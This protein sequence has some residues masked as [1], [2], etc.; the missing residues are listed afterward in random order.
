M[1]PIDAGFSKLERLSA[2]MDGEADDAAFEAA[3]ASWRN[4]ELDRSSW[5]AW[6]LI[7]DVLRSEELGGTAHREAAFVLSLRSRLNDEPSILAPVAR[8]AA[9]DASDVG[10]AQIAGASASRFGRVR[11][12]S[13]RAWTASAAVA[14]GFVV[15]AGALVVMQRPVATP[16]QVQAQAAPS[17]DVRLVSVSA[18]PKAP[19][20]ETPIVVSGQML[21]DAR[22]QQY[23]AAHKQFGGST[24][25]GVPSGFLRSA[26]TVDAPAR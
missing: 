3:C 9:I 14:A 22:L 13:R 23:L 20:A 2:V 19:V 4:E 26:I 6:H 8:A 18:A 12:R 1:T 25:L 16:S 5:H 24:A 10:T 21:R 17:S 15:V 7:G 11:S